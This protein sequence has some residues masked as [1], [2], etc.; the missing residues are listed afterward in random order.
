MFKLTRSEIRQIGVSKSLMAWTDFLI[1]AAEVVSNY[2]NK[3]HSGL[4]RIIDSVSL[5]KRHQTPLEAWNEALK[6]GAPIDRVEDWDAEDLFR[7]YEERKVRRGEIELFGNR[8]FSQE[9]SE[10]HGDNVLVGYDIHNADRITVRDQDGR[11]IC[12]A[13]WNAN[14]RAYF[15]Q[16]KVEQ[17]RQHR[18][19]GRLR[20][21]A[22]KQDEVLLEANPQRVIEHMEN[23]TVIPFNSNKHTELMAEL[24]ALPVKREKEVIYF[25]DARQL[26]KEDIQMNVNAE[27]PVQRWIRLDEH[28]QQDQEVNKEDRDYWE[29]FPMSKKFKQLK[30][31]D[32]ELKGYLAQ[33]QG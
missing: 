11:L 7:P 29:M 15:P 21:L 1:Y 28:I 2:N 24:N 16:T 25:K 17:A 12:Y 27:N 10:Y 23:Q 9:L 13:F 30:E 20:R 3:P 8:Y 26:H 22:V 33:H 14:K 6:M 18:A 32:A 31:D 4:K 5:K 19:D